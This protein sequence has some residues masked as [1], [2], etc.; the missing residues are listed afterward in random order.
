MFLVKPK[1]DTNAEPEEWRSLEKKEQSLV[2]RQDGAWR[3]NFV[4]KRVDVGA[5]M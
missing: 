4:K 2:L 1:L 3:D 5:N